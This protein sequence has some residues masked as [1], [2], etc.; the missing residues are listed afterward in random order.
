MRPGLTFRSEER[1]LLRPCLVVRQRLHD[2]DTAPA[3]RQQYRSMCRADLL[4]DAPW[5]D[6]QIGR[7][8]APPTLPRSPTATA[9]PRHR[10]RD[11]STVPVDVSCRPV[12]RCALD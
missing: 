9:R 1:A 8:R 6:L 12:A 10:A 2:R 11:T 3:T 7:T 4:H 5:I